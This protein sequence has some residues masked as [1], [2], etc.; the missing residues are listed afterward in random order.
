MPDHSLRSAAFGP[1][2]AILSIRDL[3]PGFQERFLKP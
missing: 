1:E 2:G 3:S